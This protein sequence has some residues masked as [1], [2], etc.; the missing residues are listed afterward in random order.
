LF[1]QTR[2]NDGNGDY[3]TGYANVVNQLSNNNLT[4]SSTVENLNNNLGIATGTYQIERGEKV[5]FSLTGN[6]IREQ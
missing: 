1:D 6:L 5:M 3:D 4:V 2:I